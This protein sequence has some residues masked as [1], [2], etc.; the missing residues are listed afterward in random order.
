M[1]GRERTTQTPSVGQGHQGGDVRAHGGETFIVRGIRFDI[2]GA[3]AIIRATPRNVVS[4]PIGPLASMLPLIR[5][6]HATGGF[7]S[8]PDPSFPLILAV[9]DGS[10]FPIDGWHRIA[11]AKLRGVMVLPAV[12]L[13]EAESRGIMG[14]AV[15]ARR[16][17]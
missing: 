15:P 14:H 17:G 6:D 16:A 11:E 9:L 1:I 8:A 13:T 2:D 5:H 7:G 4:I 10:Y 12:M 3:K